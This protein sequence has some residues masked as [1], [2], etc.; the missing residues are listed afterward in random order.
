MI[1]ITIV[2]VHPTVTIVRS[3]DGQTEVPTHWF[4]EIPKVNQ[5]WDLDLRHETTEAERLDRLN[6]YLVK[7]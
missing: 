7:D 6:A 1:R 2:A 3:K 5:E 4:S